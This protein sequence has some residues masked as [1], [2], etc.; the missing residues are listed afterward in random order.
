MSTLG[1]VFSSFDWIKTIIMVLLLLLLLL[2][3]IVVDIYLVTAWLS[4]INIHLYSPPPQWIII[5][6]NKI[7]RNRP[8]FLLA[9]LRNKPTWD[10]GR[11]CHKSLYIMNWSWGRRKKKLNGNYSKIFSKSNQVLKRGNMLFAFVKCIVF[12]GKLISIIASTRLWFA[13]FPVLLLALWFTFCFAID[14]YHY[15]RPVLGQNS[16]LLPQEQRFLLGIRPTGTGLQKT[17]G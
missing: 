13:S 7:I 4:K 14:L 2:L 1:Y 8:E 9:Y 3:W 15:M 5:M 12:T 6:L 11:T 17:S 16:V 10:V